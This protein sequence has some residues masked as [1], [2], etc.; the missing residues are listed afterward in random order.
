MPKEASAVGI[1]LQ[2]HCSGGRCLCLKIAG[3]EG[4]TS[5]PCHAGSQKCGGGATTEGFE[6]TTTDVGWEE[7]PAVALEG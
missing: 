2:K 7:A 6:S 4:L 1:L 5:W 3:C